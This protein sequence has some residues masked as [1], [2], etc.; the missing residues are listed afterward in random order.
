MSFA[1]SCCKF[2]IERRLAMRKGYIPPTERAF[3][4]A[5]P[6]RNARTLLWMYALFWDRHAISIMSSILFLNSFF[7]SHKRFSNQLAG[8]VIALAAFFT[9]IFV[10]HCTTGVHHNE[11]CTM[12][13]SASKC[14]VVSAIF[15]VGFA[16]ALS[17]AS[18]I[19]NL[20]AFI[21]AAHRH[22]HS[23]SNHMPSL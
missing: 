20:C 9:S 2:C 19:N 6:C 4:S 1:V 5:S 12:S 18:T 15:F 22:A 17:A 21:H 14:L 3:S 23:I 7:T 16:R 8:F 13:C 10:D 11:V